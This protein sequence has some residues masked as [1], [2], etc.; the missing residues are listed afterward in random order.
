MKTI[1]AVL[2]PLV[3]SMVPVGL[4]S[5]DPDYV[6][7]ITD[8]SGPVGG[9][10]TVATVLDMTTA[11]QIILAYDWGVCHDGPVF[12]QSELTWEWEQG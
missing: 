3:L 9:L 8:S 2:A 1:T 7:G 5:Q 11:S 4:N 10:A 12:R 6:L